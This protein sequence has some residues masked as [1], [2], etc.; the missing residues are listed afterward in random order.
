MLGLPVPV[1]MAGIGGTYRNADG[2]ERQE[3]SNVIRA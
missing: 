1:L 2:E 3:R